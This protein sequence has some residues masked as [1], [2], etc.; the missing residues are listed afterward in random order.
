MQRQMK[1]LKILHHR[2]RVSSAPNYW[3]VS[4]ITDNSCSSSI[5]GFVVVKPTAYI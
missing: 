4:D 2:S 1:S 5:P 3:A